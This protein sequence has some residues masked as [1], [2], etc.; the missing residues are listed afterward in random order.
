[1]WKGELMKI[2]AVYS[3]VAVTSAVSND[4]QGRES[5]KILL[6]LVIN[7]WSFVNSTAKGKS[8]DELIFLI[9]STLR[10]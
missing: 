3:L 4:V 8:V 6:P 9:I 5:P 2:L 1:M 7:T 10:L